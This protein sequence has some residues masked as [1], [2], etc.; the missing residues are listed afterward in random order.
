MVV[1]SAVS[2]FRLGYQYMMLTRSY[3]LI[4]HILDPLVIATSSKVYLITP[5]C[6]STRKLTKQS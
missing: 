6:R 3:H 2:M 4:M 1:L 5:E